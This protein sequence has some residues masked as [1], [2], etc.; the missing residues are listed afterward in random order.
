MT[1]NKRVRRA[2]GFCL[3][4]MLLAVQLFAGRTDVLAASGQSALNISNISLSVGQ[5]QTLKVS[6][7]KNVKWTY[8]RKSVVSVSQKGTIKAKKAG[9]SDNYR[10]LFRKKA[11][12]QCGGKQAIL[13][14]KG[15]SRRLFFTD[16]HD[17]EGCTADS[18]A[19]GW[20]FA[21]D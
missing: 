12:M 9:E 4:I 17:E 7:A 14:Q 13:Q 19:D 11:D 6:N 21:A 16:G 1:Q 15:C 20:R 2:T 3:T 18:K 10:K 8:S 5:S